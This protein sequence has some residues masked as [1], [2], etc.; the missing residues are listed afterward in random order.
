MISPELL[1]ISIFDQKVGGLP[2]G[3]LSIAETPEHRSGMML[4]GHFLHQ[5]LSNGDA[6]TLITFEN[7]I[8]FLDYFKK[9]TFDF[10]DY[11]ATGQLSFLN[12]EPS[13]SIE[14]GLTQNY[15]YIFKEIL[16]LSGSDTRR[17][18][19]NQVDALF[20]L[21][22]H[23]L[24]NSCAQKLATAVEII[25]QTVLG[26][27][28]QFNDEVHRNLSISCKKV[29]SGYFTLK[30]T[31]IEDHYKLITDKVPWYEYD[32]KAINLHLSGGN[33]FEAGLQKVS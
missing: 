20:S 1:G 33:G 5:G 13:V 25:P 11:I 19:I 30:E 26:Q 9:S 31:N 29:A 16:R 2:A 15:E 18:A 14:I 7:P 23:S 24:I 10:Y 32:T 8:N 22:N 17:I 27:F 12:F 6:C 4:L 21:H 28:I 3:G